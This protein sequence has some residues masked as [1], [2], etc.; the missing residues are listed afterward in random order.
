LFERAEVAPFDVEYIAND[1]DPAEL[2]RAPADVGKACFDISTAETDQ[3]AELTNT[4]DLAFSKMVFE[5]LP[6]VQQAYRNIYEMLAPGGV[7]LNFHP[8]L[9]SPP[10]VIN[11]LIPTS[12]PER[13][14]RRLSP[15]RNQDEQPK[16][17]A[18]YDRCRVSRSFRSGLRGMGYRK[19]WQLP[20]W[21]H[22]YFKPFPGLRECDRIVNKI[23]ERAN[24]TSIASYCYTIVV[25]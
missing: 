15:R 4:V 5:H 19:V 21:S 25:K 16:F 11:Y 23:A 2:E 13:L 3:M 9:F 20:F 7:C 14:L 12:P 22:E 18:A 6:D 10:F 1:I 24:L 17:P 8:L